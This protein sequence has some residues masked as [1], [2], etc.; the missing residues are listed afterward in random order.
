MNVQLSEYI[1][2]AFLI[3]CIIAVEMLSWSDAVVH[4]KS[5]G[6]QH[7]VIPASQGCNNDTANR[8][9]VFV[10]WS[11]NALIPACL[12]VSQTNW[13]GVCLNESAIFVK[14][15]SAVM[16]RLCVSQPVFEMDVQQHQLYEINSRDYNFLKE[17]YKA[18]QVCGFLYNP[19]HV[20]C[21]I[22][23]NI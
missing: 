11:F 14:D 2:C 3:K 7:S 18:N 1:C 4:V 8:K 17:Q 21:I 15:K 10:N 9:N 16:L 5:Q 22:P 20:W 13:V 19:C 6:M 23:G 12:N